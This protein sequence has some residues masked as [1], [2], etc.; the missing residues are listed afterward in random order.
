MT[1]SAAACISGTDTIYR[2]AGRQID[3]QIGR[4]ASRQAGKKDL[5]SRVHSPIVLEDIL[6]DK[7]ILPEH[8]RHFLLGFRC[9][10]Q[11]MVDISHNDYTATKHTYQLQRSGQH[12][13]HFGP[14]A[15]DN[16]R[17]V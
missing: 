5:Y 7:L 11:H 2:Q 6:V 4:H 10:Q 15:T 17:Q 12:R 16:T 13:L 9:L 8:G 14:T 1:H 3:R